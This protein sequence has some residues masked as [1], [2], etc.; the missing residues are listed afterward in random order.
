MAIAMALTAACSP[1]SVPPVRT[2]HRP[3]AVDHLATV[4]RPA[5][6]DRPLAAKVDDFGLPL[7]IDIQVPETPKEIQG[8]SPPI[9]EEPCRSGKR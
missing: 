5:T 1:K 9:K 7:E 2:V 6:A 8:P 3:A 4:D